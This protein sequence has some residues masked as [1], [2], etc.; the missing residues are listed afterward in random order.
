VTSIAFDVVTCQDGDVMIP[1]FGGELALEFVGTRRSRRTD[2][3]EQLDSPEAL[4]AWFSEA[5]FQPQGDSTH[6]DV[7][8]AAALREA[9]YSLVLCRMERREFT[10]TDLQVVN[11]WATQPPVVRTL[12]ASGIDV[13][14]TRA[15]SFASVA[16]AAIDLL[17]LPDLTI[18]ECGRDLCTRLFVDHSH[19]QRRTW[20]GMSECGDRVKA[21]AYRARRKRAAATRRS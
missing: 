7:V 14:S 8:A 18:K 4:D 2:P 12:T 11:H 13:V 1:C 15:T 16:R 5:G 20:C 19:G 10:S 9:I 6:D 17:A 3:E 21:A